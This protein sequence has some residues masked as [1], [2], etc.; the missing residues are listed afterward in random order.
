MNCYKCK[1]TIDRIYSNSIDS[2]EL[3]SV[4]HHIQ[5]CESCRNYYNVMETMLSDL[6]S[7]EERPLPEGFHNRLHFALKREALK[8]AGNLRKYSTALKIAAAGAC[9]VLLIMAA[10]NLL[11]KSKLDSVQN[12]VMEEAAEESLEIMESSDEILESPKDYS[13]A[14]DTET[15][16]ADSSQRDAVEAE[17]AAVFAAEAETSEQSSELLSNG[18]SIVIMLETDDP[19]QIYDDLLELMQDPLPETQWAIEG[20]SEPD[21]YKQIRIIT[22]ADNALIIAQEI[23]ARYS[24]N[25]IFYMIKSIEY[26]NYED[27]IAGL[28]NA[29]YVFV[30]IK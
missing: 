17:E 7:F 5:N 16:S 26:E 21:N 24:D 30:L 22:D 9:S 6:A 20:E 23:T 29:G 19:E 18:D 10:V 11:P 28:Q 14:A 27:E 25:I 12:V 13:G 8:P 3:Q 4:L 2:N 1:K 15:S